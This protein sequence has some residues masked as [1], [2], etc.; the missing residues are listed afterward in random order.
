MANGG[1]TQPGGLEWKWVI[2]GVV[3]GLVIVGVSFF[4]VIPTFNSIPIQAL[5]M[6]MGFVAM[7]AVVGYFSPGV[8][9][10]EP[11]IAGGIVAVLML[12]LLSLSG[13]ELADD[14]GR[15][16]LGLVFGIAFA[17]VGAWMGE[18]LQGSGGHSEEETKRMFTD[19]LWKWVI[20][21][22]ILGFMLNVLGVFLITPLFG[23]NL[24]IAF[25]VFLVSLVITGFIVGLKSP[26]ITLKEPAIAGFFAVLLDWAFLELAIDLKVPDGDLAFGLVLGFLLSLFGAWLGERY[27]ISLEA[28]SSAA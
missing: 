15:N 11:S 12:I 23:L 5:V 9:I 28:R 7:G 16:G 8:T 4:I 27:Q 18:K 19:V 13:R 26:G 25:G 2:V 3:V 14:I 20:V 10:K 21:G 17:W 24:A 22:V 1:S 6:L